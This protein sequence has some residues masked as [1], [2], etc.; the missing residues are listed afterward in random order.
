MNLVIVSKSN[1]TNDEKWRIKVALDRFASS[2]SSGYSDSGYAEAAY[3][4]NVLS[5]VIGLKEREELGALWRDTYTAKH[6]ELGKINR[7]ITAILDRVR[8][9]LGIK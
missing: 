6:H 8:I 5:E 3:A 2:L 1:I 9:E 4:F 7:E